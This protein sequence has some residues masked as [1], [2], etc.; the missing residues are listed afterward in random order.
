MRLNFVKRSKKAFLFYLGV[1][2]TFVLVINSP[3]AAQEPSW[4]MDGEAETGK[5]YQNAEEMTS[6]FPLLKDIAKG[7]KLPKPYGIS[8]VG[9]YNIQEYTITSGD[10]SV[11][12]NILSIDV[13]DVKVQ[14][15]ATTG[16]LR[17]DFWLLP[18]LNL[19]GTIGAAN[20]NTEIILPESALQGLF[21]PDRQVLEMQFK[22]TIYGIGMTGAWAWKNILLNMSFTNTWSDLD[23]EQAGYKAKEFINQL[24]DTR[25]GYHYGI[26]NAW[27]GARWMSTTQEYIGTVGNVEIDVKI[28]QPVWNFLIGSNI[29]FHDLFGLSIE[30]GV[31]ERLSGSINFGYRF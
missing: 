6:V 16:L 19:Y 10:F 7:K 11:N 26:A 24:W 25:L 20:V 13:S 30:L 22:G 21:A 14:P 1:A 4:I 28:E 5:K 2:I 15:E 8:V 29:N 23:G 12:G 17:G 27:V 3:T 9:A 31:G 18:F